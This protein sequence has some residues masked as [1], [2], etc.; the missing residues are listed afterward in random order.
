M[1][2]SAHYIHI[3]FDIKNEKPE[4]KEKKM[5]QKQRDEMRK[6]KLRVEKSLG[7]TTILELFNA[8]FCLS[9]VKIPT[10]GY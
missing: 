5:M 4:E 2:Y 8:S 3:P 7:I 9:T 6:T 1:R 10:A